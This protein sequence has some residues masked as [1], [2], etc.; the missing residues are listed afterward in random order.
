MAR[1]TV[2]WEKVES[3]Y[4]AGLLSLREMGKVHGV[5][6][7]GITKRA[8]AHGWSRDLSAAIKA[9]ADAMVARDEVA[10][11]VDSNR[12]VNDRLIVDVN[13]SVLAGIKIAHRQDIAR[14]RRL[15]MS[16]L[17]D[18]E[19]Q[20]SDKPLLTQMG[21]AICDDTPEGV[22]RRADVLT[23]LSTIPGR[24]D[25]L[26]KLADAMKSLVAMEREAYGI[27]DTKTVEVIDKTPKGL[28]HFY[29][30]A[31]YPDEAGDGSDA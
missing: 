18:L 31:A 12:A 22:G 30:G 7:T 20:T 5:S 21:E 25:S 27:V 6:H 15:A 17:S 24:I 8:E 9:K 1:T 28:N 23:R 3:D 16:M 2:D 29:A 13:A 4:R 19:A 14:M 26:K 10:T 11:Q